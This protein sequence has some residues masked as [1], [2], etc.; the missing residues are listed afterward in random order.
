MADDKP[1]L[2][3][4]TTGGT[5]G[6]VRDAE[7]TARPPTNPPDF[8]RDTPDLETRY[9][10]DVVP[11]MNKDSSNVTPADWT[12][13]VRAIH[14]RWDAGYDGFVV[15]HGTD[16]MH[17]SASAVALGLGALPLE[18]PVV[19]TGAL[20]TADDESPDGPGNLA[21]ACRVAAQDFGE[22]LIVM[23]GKILRGCRAM[24]RQVEGGALDAFGAAE[25]DV[26]G[27]LL[28][29]AVW[30]RMDFAARAE[31]VETLGLGSRE[32]RDGFAAGVLPIALSPGLEPGMFGSAVESGDCSGVLLQT[33]GSG[34]VPN[35]TVGGASSWIDFIADATR[36]GV[37]VLLT[38]PL[39]GGSTLGSIYGPGRDAV[40]A[41]G[42]VVGDLTPACAV[43]KFRWAIAQ[44]GRGEVEAVRRIMAREWIAEMGTVEAALWDRWGIEDGGQ[45]R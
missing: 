5:I 25:G 41:G 3:L 43:V 31:S 28:A 33:L 17:Y 24:K 45:E 37:P 18:R 44:A 8:L 20:R 14:E 35:Q 26:V 22:V 6:M 36:R 38:S 29:D 23:G 32:W 4:I 1:K 42:I 21:D 16:T 39:R 27:G 2:C 10:I 7:G 12:A 40:A 11:L 34:N 19:F 13:M 15:A 30:T 9:A